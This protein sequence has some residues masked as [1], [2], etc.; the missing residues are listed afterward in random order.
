M[1]SPVIFSLAQLH[2]IRNVCLYYECTEL[3]V[4][5]LLA[6]LVVPNRFKI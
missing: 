1:L 3:W 5:L 4:A 6:G 2:R